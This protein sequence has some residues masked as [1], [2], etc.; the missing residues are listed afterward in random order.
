MPD[1]DKKVLVCNPG[2]TVPEGWKPHPGPQEEFLKSALD[3]AVLYGGTFHTVE[4]I[5]GRIVNCSIMTEEQ[6]RAQYSKL[7]PSLA[8]RWQSCPGTL[9]RRGNPTMPTP[10]QQLAWMDGAWPPVEEPK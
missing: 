4:M 10:E 5:P 8:E 7:S 1:D 9:T 6:I 2:S 3:E